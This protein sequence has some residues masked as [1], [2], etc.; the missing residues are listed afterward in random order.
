MRRRHGEEYWT[1]HQMDAAS[2]VALRRITGL[3]PVAAR[4]VALSDRARNQL[5]NTT[6][7]YE[8]YHFDRSQPLRTSSLVRDVLRSG[9]S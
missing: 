7:L 3:A 1:D 2:L 6:R 9:G 5:E 8:R 4:A